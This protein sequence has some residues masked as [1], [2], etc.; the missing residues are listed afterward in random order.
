M[1]EKHFL[2]ASEVRPVVRT[3][4]RNSWLLLTQVEMGAKGFAG[5]VHSLN[6]GGLIPAHIHENE[7]EAL[8]FYSGQGV[9]RLGSEE[10]VIEPES[11]LLAPAGIE[12]EVRNTGNDPLK[13][14]W[15]FS[16]P[17]PEH[18]TQEAYHKSAQAAA[19]PQR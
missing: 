17:L 18:A 19:P 3:H 13:F 11:V 15:V 4:G 10:F 16:P 12:H 1:A 9:C 8:F 6:P 14:V 5:G 2:K 7:Q